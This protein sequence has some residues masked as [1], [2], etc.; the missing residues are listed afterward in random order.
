MI[1]LHM[2]HATWQV[3]AVVF[4][5]KT[6]IVHETPPV[7]I[8]QS[9]CYVLRSQQCTKV[10]PSALYTL[11]VRVL[12]Q[13]CACAYCSFTRLSLVSSATQRSVVNREAK[14]HAVYDELACKLPGKWSVSAALQQQSG[15]AS[16][17]LNW[18]HSLC[19]ALV[20]DCGLQG[21]QSSAGLAQHQARCRAPPLLC[22]RQVKEI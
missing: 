15:P 11:Y 4:C 20:R 21:E 18:Q 7:C 2:P 9:S 17:L 8:S 16:V 10:S 22:Q 12:L 6:G 13:G 5:H 19:S 14:A 1:E 3:C